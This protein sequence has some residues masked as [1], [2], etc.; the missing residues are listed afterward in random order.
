MR[1]ER[2]C[3]RKTNII[4]R[5]PLSKDINTTRYESF[6]IIENE[7]ER[8]INRIVD[9]VAAD[10]GCAMCAASTRSGCYIFRAGDDTVVW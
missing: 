4:K 10:G 9:S 8:S 5:K 7:G 2:V 1:V 3:V 6:A